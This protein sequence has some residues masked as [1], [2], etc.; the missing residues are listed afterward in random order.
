MLGT[1]AL[2]SGYYD[3][4]YKR[5]EQVRALISQDFTHAFEKFDVLVSP[6][7]PSVA[8]K[9]GEISTPYEMY[10]QDVLTIP[11]NL[12]GNCGVSIPGGFSQGLPVGLQLL[13]NFF[14]E[15]T[16][17]RVADAFERVTDYHTCWPQL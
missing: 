11:A 10:M 14:A 5:A 8:F 4:Y 1:Y 6:A 3:A 7:S 12:A 15:D 13:G 17:L 9:L 2:S 16:I